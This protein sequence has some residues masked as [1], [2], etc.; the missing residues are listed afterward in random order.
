MY[1]VVSSTLKIKKTDRESSANE[2]KTE[3]LSHTHTQFKKLN[4]N[5]AD[6]APTDDDDDDEKSGS[7]FDFLV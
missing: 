5:N 3:K 7:L 1:L 2:P 4:L 6:D